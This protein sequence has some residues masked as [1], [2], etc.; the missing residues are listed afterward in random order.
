MENENVAATVHTV[1]NLTTSGNEK[2]KEKRPLVSGNV[3][4]DNKKCISSI[5]TSSVRNGNL[6][7]PVYFLE[8]KQG[9][10]FR[11]MGKGSLQ[12]SKESASIPYLNHTNP[13]HNYTCHFCKI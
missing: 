13:I 6:E 8:V 10:T 12:C 11:K 3:M 9:Y 1:T 7:V 4:T 2:G 5:H